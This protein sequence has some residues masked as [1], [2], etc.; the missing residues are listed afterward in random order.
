MRFAIPI[1]AVLV[2]AL[3][4]AQ[5]QAA[6][7]CSSFAVFE[8]YD[9]EGSR[10]K[11][12]HGRGSMKKYFPLPEGAPSDTQKVPGTCKKK[13]TK[14][15]TFDVKATG[16]RLSV[17]QIRT[18]FEGKM[19]ND[20]DDPEW[21]GEFIKKLIADETEVV[22]VIRPGMGKGAPLGINTVYMPITDEELAEIKR[23]EDQ[24]EEIE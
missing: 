21:L 10:V 20:P 3:G 8:K 4:A 13:V 9:S 5:A 1:L 11:I 18:N 22:V 6:G 23:L 12:K 24:A 7:S 14:E 17:T 2:L 15:T 16:G 19:L